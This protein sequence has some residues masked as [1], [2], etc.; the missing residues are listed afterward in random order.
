[1]YLKMFKMFKC[2]KNEMLRNY[3]KDVLADRNDIFFSNI[4]FRNFYISSSGA[5]S[6]IVFF[7]IF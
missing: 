2:S 5:F 7:P 6:L 3:R 1:M 4:F